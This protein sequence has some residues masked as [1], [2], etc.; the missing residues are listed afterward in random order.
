MVKRVY[1]FYIGWAM[2][3]AGMVMRDPPSKDGWMNVLIWL[4][5]GLAISILSYIFEGIGQN[6]NIGEA[7][8]D[9]ETGKQ[10]PPIRAGDER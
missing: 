4:G 5:V 3:M 1:W 2:V 8:F 7:R 10:L 6:P 9:S